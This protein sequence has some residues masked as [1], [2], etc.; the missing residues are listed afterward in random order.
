MS[1]IVD[2]SRFKSRVAADACLGPVL[3]ADLAIRDYGQGQ[4]YHK[5]KRH[6]KRQ[7]ATLI[8]IEILK[9]VSDETTMQW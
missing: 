5:D 7:R 8:S 2:A 6:F 9:T 4:D 3:R 1:Q